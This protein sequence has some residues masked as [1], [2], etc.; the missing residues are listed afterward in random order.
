MPRGRKGPPQESIDSILLAIS[1]R[2]DIDSDTLTHY[3]DRLDE[4]WGE[5]ARD[6]VLHLLR[7]GDRSAHAA[8]IL[9]LSELATDA[10]LEDLED[11]ITD[12]TVNDMAK[13]TLSP[14]LK[15]LGSDLAD[16]GIVEYLNDPASAMLQMQ[17]HLLELVGQSEL[18]VESVL[19]DVLSMPVERRL[20]FISWL[21]SSQDQRAA[22]LLV[23]LLE[24]QST[25]VSLAAVEA[26]EQLG[27]L[28]FQQA[29]PAL[30]YLVTTTSNRELKQRARTALGH[31]MMLTNPGVEFEAPA[32]LPLHEA[33]VSFIDGT[34]SQMVMLSWRRP[35][36][37][38]K[39]IN[40]LC[41]DIWGIKDCYG[42][43]EMTEQHWSEL[44]DEMQ[45]QSFESLPVSLEYA[46]SLVAEAYGHNR[47]FRH[48]LPVAYSIWRPF[49]EGDVPFKKRGRTTPE[50]LDLPEFTEEVRD[51][52]KQG[53]RLFDLP[54]Y[55]SWLF[56]PLEK[57][58][59]YINRYW[60]DPLMEHGDPG[61]GRRGQRKERQRLRDLLTG[62]VDEMLELEVDRQSRQLYT[63][64]LLRQ[65]RLLEMTQKASEAELSRVV[66]AALHPDSGVPLSEQPFLRRMLELSIEQG[67]YQLMANILELGPLDLE[68]LN[69]F[70]PK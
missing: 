45:Q 63:E 50:Q 22:N 35:D 18:G 65:A 3:F 11:F 24:T 4:E 56:Q 32:S 57:L 46:R 21:G 26:L 62:L 67:P 38:L 53:E 6:K 49:I 5:G 27:P 34:G 14:V 48:K 31:L 43:D 54:V 33:R 7:S 19:E 37:L 66:A 41:Q 13:L 23:P 61:V 44:S 29:I 15:E 47:R 10:D 39:G 60:S 52:A 2:D 70:S 17:M 28:A 1:R 25:R 9:I 36:G 64:R 40:I 69:L 68:Q 16:D 12:P 51:L 8:S 55:A 30:N 58:Q 20:G 42:T 59:N